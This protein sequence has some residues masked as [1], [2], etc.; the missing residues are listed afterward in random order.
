MVVGSKFTFYLPTKLLINRFVWRKEAFV[1]CR[2]RIKVWSFIVLADLSHNKVAK[3]SELNS[4]MESN[5][6][7]KA[8]TNNSGLGT[9]GQKKT[10][11][12]N[13]YCENSRK[14]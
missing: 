4:K 1:I 8:T 11:G 2:N 12:I 6:E 13:S 9:Y 14:Y 5:S 7:H 10:K 3:C